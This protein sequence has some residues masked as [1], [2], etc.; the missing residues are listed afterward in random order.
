MQ[1]SESEQVIQMMFG[2]ILSNAI[3]SVGEMGVADSIAADGSASIDELA[4]AA[5]T[6]CHPRALYRTM[7]YLASNGVFLELDSQRFGHTPLSLTLRSDHPQSI[8]PIVRLVQRL[9]VAH[10]HFIHSLRTGESA[11]TEAYGE[12]LFSYLAKHPDDAAIFDAGMPALHGNE[13][14]PMLDAYDF[15]NVATLMDVG[16]GGGTLIAAT[17]QRHASMR[18]VLFDLDHVVDRARTHLVQCGVDDRCDVVGGNFFESVPTGADA[19]VMRHIVHDYL[20]E[21]AVR[22]L[23]NCHAALP[24]NGRILLVEAVIPPGNDPSPSK[25]MDMAMM[26]YPG[27]MER[28]ADEYATLFHASGFELAG[29][30]PTSSM[31]SVIE[32]H[33]I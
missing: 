1:P 16:G 32:G 12:P 33:P 15:S 24:N 9:H 6:G 2:A 22:I 23:T 27:G 29:V 30:T 13:T 4:A 17:L 26:L 5:T 11:L 14:G 20:D 18:G 10:P 21:D 7:R 31:V 3:A 28:T 19:I 8:L 25:V